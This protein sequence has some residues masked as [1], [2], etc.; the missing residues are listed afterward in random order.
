[1]SDYQGIGE[2]AGDF[3]GM[4]VGEI[5]GAGN[6]AEAE[7]LRQ[8]AME[9]YGI[10]I[11]PVDDLQA[12]ALQSQAAGAQGNADAK[13]IRME[14]LKQLAQRGQEGYNIQDRAAIA[15]TLS[16]VDQAARGRNEAILRGVDPNSG[17]ALA[18]RRANA[19][20]AAQQ[21]NRR[22]L[23]IAAG[24]RRAALD[25]LARSG[26]MAG[27]VDESEF[28]QAFQRGQAGDAIS[29]FNES[30]RLDVL[31]GNQ[32]AKQARTAMEMQRANARAEQLNRNAGAQETEAQRKARLARG[33]GAGAGRVAGYAAGA[34]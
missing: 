20:D 28:G 14:A 16:E 10:E 21:A 6:R 25:A 24:S 19:Q 22:G 34:F 29:R 31:R 18:M 32:Q 23:D 7:R 3:L 2:G 17:A 4:I 8:Q 13:A 11:P 27:Q 33:V 15:D 26:T 9:E 1:M 5:L 12:Q 30:N